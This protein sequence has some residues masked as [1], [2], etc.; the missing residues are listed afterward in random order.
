MKLKSSFRKVMKPVLLTAI[1]ILL[2]GSFSACEELGYPPPQTE[3]ADTAPEPVPETGKTAINTK[4]TVILAVYQRLLDQAVSS[5]AKIYLSDFYANCDN[6]T[7]ASEYFKDG[8]DTWHVVVDM[9]EE[10]DW[11]LRPYWQQ[12]SWFVFRNGD[13]IPSYLFNANAL[14]IEADLQSLSPET[15]PSSD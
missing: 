11:T 12:A 13:V 1:V 10:S 6:W 8:S 9:S 3:P 14:R 4:D 5:D 7:A 15:A 2:V